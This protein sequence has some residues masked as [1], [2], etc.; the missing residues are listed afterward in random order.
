[1]MTPGEFWRRVHLLLTRDRAS[2]ELE[3]EMRL[4]LELRTEALRTDGDT[5]EEARHLARRQF[6]N[7][8]IVEETSRDAWGLVPGHRGFRQ[9]PSD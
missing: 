9:R 3:E 7:A 1:M 8:T 2:A 4:H 6:G 5:V